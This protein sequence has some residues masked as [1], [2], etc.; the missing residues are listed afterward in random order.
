MGDQKADKLGSLVAV[1][2]SRRPP[3]ES[4]SGELLSGPQVLDPQIVRIA[5][6]KRNGVL[7]DYD[8]RMRIRQR[9]EDAFDEGA[10]SK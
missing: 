1:I 2:A 4:L 7:G 10:Q 8:A 5:P 6:G 9:G 3:T